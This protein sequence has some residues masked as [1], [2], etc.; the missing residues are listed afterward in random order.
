MSIPWILVLIFESLLAIVRCEVEVEVLRSLE[1]HL[2]VEAPNPL[3]AALLLPW[4][5]E[6][7]LS[8]SR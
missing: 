5:A 4:C 8:L 2:L 6:I 3:M 7:A 1:S